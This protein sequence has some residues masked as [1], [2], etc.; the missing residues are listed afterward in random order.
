MKRMASGQRMLARGPTVVC[1]KPSAICKACDTTEES[2]MSSPLL[3]ASDFN[4]DE[5][6]AFLMSDL[7]KTACSFPT[8]MDSSGASPLA[9]S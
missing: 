8:S 3:G 5:L 9:R 6:D 7:R 1:Q 2:G 4:L